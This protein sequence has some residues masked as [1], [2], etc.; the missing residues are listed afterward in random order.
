MS[1]LQSRFS[2][3]LVDDDPHIIS[4]LKTAFSQTSY[5]IYTA[6]NGPS[7]LALMEK[8]RIDATLI[9]L[10]M[11]EM[12]G[13]TLLKEIKQNYPETMAIMLSGY[14]CIE[15]AVKAIKLGAVDF[16]EK[17]ISIV[18]LK[19]CLAQLYEKWKA[20]NE[21]P[22]FPAKIKSSFSYDRLVGI[23]AAA[24][25]LKQVIAQVGPSEAPVLIQGQTGTGKELVARAVHY[26]SRRSKNNFMPVD[27]AAISQSVIESELFGHVKG[28]FTGAHISTL[29]IIRSADKGTLFL[30]EIGELPLSVQAKLLRTIQEREVRPVGTSKRYPVDIRVIAA[31]NRDLEEEVLKGGFNEALFYRLNVVNINVQRLKDRKEDIPLLVRH[32]VQSFAPALS[33]VKDIAADALACL[34]EY[35]WPGNIRELENVI[36][37]ALTLGTENLIRIWDL[38]K[39]IYALSAA[40]SQTHTKPTRGTLAWYEKKAIKNA[41]TISSGNRR[42]AAMLLDIGEATLYR[43]IKKYHLG[44]KSC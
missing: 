39:K 4:L 36:H 17:P 40:A 7:A 30:D 29:G 35:D 2:C 12:D 13:L 43:K 44:R 18:G 19:F 21:N 24:Q 31:T 26:H 15:S 3:L 8:V 32:F 9:D 38:P 11:P 27:C 1:S 41:L 23:S 33:P 20:K 16:L 37:R 42:N 28:A 22:I 5:Q 34:E 25:K 6:M 14:G 10:V